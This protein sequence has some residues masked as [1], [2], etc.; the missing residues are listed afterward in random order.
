MGQYLLQE[1]SLFVTC[2]HP[3]KQPG[4][5]PP[6]ARRPRW[7]PCI[8]EPWKKGK[9]KKP[10]FSFTCRQETAFSGSGAG[11]RCDGMPC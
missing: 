9:V 11:A 5:A 2:I 1:A 4:Q 8:A 7:P 3:A 10:T 6:R